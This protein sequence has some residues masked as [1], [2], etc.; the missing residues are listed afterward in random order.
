MEK[1]KGCPCGAFGKCCDNPD[2]T[3][4]DHE[5]TSDC[6]EVCEDSYELVCRNCGESCYHEL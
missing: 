1:E 5:C 2:I 4:G 6:E 3:D